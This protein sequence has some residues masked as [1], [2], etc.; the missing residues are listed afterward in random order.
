M[1]ISDLFLMTVVVRT[2]GKNVTIHCGL[3]IPRSALLISEHAQGHF[4]RL[5]TTIDYSVWITLRSAVN[6]SEHT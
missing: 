4:F 5:M 6:I 1:K 3:W 2:D